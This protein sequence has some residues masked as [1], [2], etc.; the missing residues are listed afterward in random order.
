MQ[1][2][3]KKSGSGVPLI[4]LHGLY[5]SSD[6]WSTV[7]KA[8][9]DKFTVYCIDQRNHG[10]S[11]H[12]SEHN[13]NLMQDDLLEFLNFHNIDKAILL[14]HSMGGKVAMLFSLLHPE[15]I[16]K[17]IIVDIAPKEYKNLLNFQPHAILYL[18]IMQAFVNVDVTLTKSRRKIEKEF[19]QYVPDKNICGFI[20][21]NLKRDNDGNFRWS[22][23]IDALNNHLPDILNGIDFAKVKFNIELINFPTLFIRGEKSDFILDEDKTTIKQF[24]Q[25]AEFVTIFNAGHLV[26]TDQPGFFLNAVFGFLKINTP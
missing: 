26:H 25:N 14:G 18:N 15:R 12:S 5:G 22:I 21:K 9:S 2:A 11:P 7:G 10:N 23:N 24:F 19:Y 13:Y 4:I 20:L 8:L 6:N 16:L 3:F 1:L 17:L